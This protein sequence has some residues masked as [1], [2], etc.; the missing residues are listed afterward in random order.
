MSETIPARKLQA[1]IARLEAAGCGIVM[2]S[3]GYSRA[4]LIVD[5]RAILRCSATNAQ[6][7]ERNPGDRSGP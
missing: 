6:K 1:I 3:P 5:L 2:I 4:E 7:D